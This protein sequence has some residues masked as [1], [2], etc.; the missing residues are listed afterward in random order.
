M[1]AV[2][3]Q[4]ISPRHGQPAGIVSRGAAALV[5]FG[6]VWLISAAISLSVDLVQSV[7]GTDASNDL[8][9]LGSGSDIS[10]D[11]LLGNFSDNDWVA[12]VGVRGEATFGPV[13]PFLAIDGSFADWSGAAVLD[14]NIVTILVPPDLKR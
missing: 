10:Y 13:T 5:D 11:G 7:L 14:S 2:A 3:L 9:A 8:G 12:N 1:S 4:E 6:V